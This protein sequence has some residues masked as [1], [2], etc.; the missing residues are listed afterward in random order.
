M[1]CIIVVFKLHI[2]NLI[3]VLICEFLLKTAELEQKY[4]FAYNFSTQCRDSIVRGLTKTSNE[5][6]REFGQAIPSFNKV[7]EISDDID[8]EQHPQRLHRLSVNRREDSSIFIVGRCFLPASNQTT[9][10]HHLH[11]PV[12]PLLDALAPTEDLDEELLEE[13]LVE[14]CLDV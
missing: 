1:L 7:D 8:P 3:N 13:E 9:V 2:P 6:F 12:P 10:C 11:R 14:E 4:R 5:R